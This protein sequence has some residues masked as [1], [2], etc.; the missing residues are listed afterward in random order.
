MKKYPLIFTLLFALFT[1]SSK[2]QKVVEQLIGTQQSYSPLF[3]SEAADLSIMFAMAY[4]LKTMDT[5][6]YVIFEVNAAKTQN[7]GGAVSVGVFGKNLAGAGTSYYSIERTKGTLIF[8]YNKFDTVVRY[9]N[10]VAEYTQRNY[11]RSRILMYSMD[12]FKISMEI[13]YRG[14]NDANTAYDRFYY[15]SIDNSTFKL[16]Q[17]QF[18]DLTK[19]TINEMKK[20]WDT[21]NTNKML[22]MMKY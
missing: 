4:D 22:P 20:A 8:D 6:F 7:Q 14:G 9:F 1:I 15:L 10:E 17:N 21:Y 5:A 18:L 12:N 3:G 19:N 16:K 2:G 11:G 13:I